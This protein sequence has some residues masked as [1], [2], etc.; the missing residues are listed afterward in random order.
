MKIVQEI[1]WRLAK[2]DPKTGKLLNKNGKSIMQQCF[3]DFYFGDNTEDI[4][5]TD[6]TDLHSLPELTPEFAN[7]LL[8]YNKFHAHD[9]LFNQPEHIAFLGHE[10]N[11]K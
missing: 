1:N 4:Q 11:S 5:Y 9:G 2:A 8:E 6:V 7:Q 3:E 10:L